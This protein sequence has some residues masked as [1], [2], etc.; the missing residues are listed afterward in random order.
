MI[1]QRPLYT[2]NKRANHSHVL[3]YE[4]AEIVSQ[5]LHLKFNIVS[6]QNQKFQL[7]EEQKKAIKFDEIVT[8][9]SEASAQFNE[10]LNVVK[11]AVLFR[12]K[13]LSKLIY[14]ACLYYELNKAEFRNITIVE[15][16]KERKA[17]KED[18]TKSF[19]YGKSTAN[20]YVRINERHKM[21]YFNEFAKG[22]VE[23]SLALNIKEYDRFLAKIEA[24]KQQ[25]LKAKQL[26]AVADI[27]GTTPSLEGTTDQESNVI[28]EALE[29]VTT[30]ADKKADKKADNVKPPKTDFILE[31][32]QDKDV[33]TEGRLTKKRCELI[34]GKLLETNFDILEMVQHQLAENEAQVN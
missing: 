18:F 6:T 24:I 19:G 8:A 34:I 11:A 28:E 30:E 13:V 16:G 20:M 14:N 22:C 17:T 9:E 29:I 31:T 26:E 4:T 7:T 1:R 33:I 3:T 15:D 10:V 25:E 21:K 12:V 23:T 2:I 32:I 5:Y 27:G